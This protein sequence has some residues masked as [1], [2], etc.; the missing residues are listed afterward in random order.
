MLKT[1]FWEG[2]DS[3]EKH[4]KST[5]WKVQYN[6]IYHHVT[7]VNFKVPDCTFIKEA[8]HSSVMINLKTS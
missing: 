7:N 6:L 2:I 5:F 3:K 8:T 4:A 1:T